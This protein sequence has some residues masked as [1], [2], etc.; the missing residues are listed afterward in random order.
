MRA[1]S[2]TP[3]LQRRR[4]A[5]WCLGLAAIASVAL[6]MTSPPA[7]A[8]APSPAAATDTLLAQRATAGR[9]FVLNLP[10]RID[11]EPVARYSAYRAPLLSWTHERSLVWETRGTPPGEHRFRYLAHRADPEAAPDTLTLVITLE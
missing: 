6:G 4:A 9:V 2:P 8:H 1:E 7:P 10:P 11:G 5:V 3:P